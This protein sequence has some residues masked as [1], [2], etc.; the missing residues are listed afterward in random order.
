MWLEKYRKLEPDLL[1]QRISKLEQELA[2]LRKK[3][4]DR[5]LKK[6]YP[7]HD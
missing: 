4:E 7:T 2:Y 6:T 5:Q 1:E 3:L